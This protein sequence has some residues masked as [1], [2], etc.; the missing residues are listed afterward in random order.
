MSSFKNE[1]IKK[2]LSSILTLEVFELVAAISE[3]KGKEGLKCMF[4]VCKCILNVC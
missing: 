4:N 1:H 3:Y 2:K